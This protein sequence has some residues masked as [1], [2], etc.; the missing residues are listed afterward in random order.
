MPLLLQ[1]ADAATREILREKRLGKKHSQ[2]VRDIIR[3]RTIEALARRRAA[4]E[5]IAPQEIPKPVEELASVPCFY[6]ET[7]VAIYKRS[8]AWALVRVRAAVWGD[9][10]RT[11]IRLK[12]LESWRVVEGGDGYVGVQLML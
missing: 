4:G 6:G 9:H 11:K 3:K 2:E 12:S 7:Q 5:A 10:R 8:K 1:R